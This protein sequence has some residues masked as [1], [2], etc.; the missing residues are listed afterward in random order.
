M[1]CCALLL[2]VLF[3]LRDRVFHPDGLLLEPSAISAVSAYSEG[4]HNTLQFSSAAPF[5]RYRIV[6]VY[7]HDPTAFTQ[8][9]VFDEGLLYESTGRYGSS[10]LR[11]VELETGK[12]L[13]AY[14][15]PKEYFGEGLTLWENSLIQLT[16]QSGIG[17][18]YAKQTF[19]KQREFKYGTEGWGLTHDGKSLIMSDGSAVLHFLDPVTFS[20]TRQIEVRDQGTPITFLNELEYINGEIFANIWRRD[21]IARISPETGEVLGWID[22]RNLRQELGA[23]RDIDVLN[24]IAYDHMHGRLFVTGKLWPKLFEIELVPW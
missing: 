21:V 22:F 9:L 8:G 20:E 24:G 18:V 2:G 16:W 6:N 3:H 23:N 14:E 1:F 17:F 19:T 7:P 10:S 11:K 13:K 4:L 12:V 15:L 5:Y